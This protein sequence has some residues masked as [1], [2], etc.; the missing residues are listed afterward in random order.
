MKTMKVHPLCKLFGE[1][2]PMPEEQ[3]AEMVANI[4][5]NGIK[6]PILV[7]QQQ[8]TI[9]DGHTRWK[10]A[11]ELELTEDQIPFEVFKGNPEREADEIL[12][13]NLYRR[14]MTDDQRVA[15]VSKLRGP[16]LETEAK[17]RQSAGGGDKRSEAYH[18]NNKSDPDDVP[19][20]AFAETEISSDAEPIHVAAKIAK[21]AGVSEHKGRQAEKARK[22]G[23]LENVIAG[24][25]KLHT[26]AKKTPSKRKPREP[27]PWEDS[28][29]AHWTRFINHYPPDVRRQVHSL[30]LGWIEP[31]AK[32]GDTDEPTT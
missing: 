11:Y 10:I 1:L 3:Y 7:N 22:A 12:S 5:A 31:N 21:E 27:V 2:A 15:I 9:L 6:V 14:N 30:V 4:K 8:N 25:E 24:K 13:R 19:Q 20:T 16:Q 23:T 18:Q 28:V 26:A 32:G 29:Y 17:E